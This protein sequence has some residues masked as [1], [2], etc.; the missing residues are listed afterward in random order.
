[1]N[2]EGLDIPPTCDIQIS[3]SYFERLL[4][5]SNTHSKSKKCKHEKIKW[6]KCWTTLS[7]P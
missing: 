5:E 1:M 7:K 4:H 3:I 2:L 6:K